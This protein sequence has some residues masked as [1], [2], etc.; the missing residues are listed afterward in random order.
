MHICKICQ[1]RISTYTKINGIGHNTA[2]RRYCL[3]CSPFQQHHRGIP[4][5]GQRGHPRSINEP[6]QCTKCKQIL[7]TS[8]F[9]PKYSKVTSTGSLSSY[10]KKCYYRYQLS[11]DTEN[12]KKAIAL[13]GGKCVECGYNKH[14]AAMQF[15]HTGKEPK[16]FGWNQLRH[17]SWSTII[18]ELKKCVLVCANCHIIHH[19]LDNKQQNF[20]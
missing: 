3:E 14:W 18:K 16:K 8:C 17:Q 11:K 13:L 10:C 9:Y 15:H 6:K 20:L 5:T 1:K 4:Q 7:A 12:K 19:S 2:N